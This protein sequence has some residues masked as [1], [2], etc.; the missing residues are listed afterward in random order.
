MAVRSLILKNRRA[1]TPHED[2]LAD[3]FIITDIKKGQH[4]VFHHRNF[5]I[6][7][8]MV[9]HLLQVLILPIDDFFLTGCKSKDTSSDD[10]FAESEQFDYEYIRSFRSA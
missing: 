10:Y 5:L 1:A 9:Q 7:K 4:V 6:S 8:T 2:K 3:Y